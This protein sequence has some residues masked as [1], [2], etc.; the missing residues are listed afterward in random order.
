MNR[1]ILEVKNVY[2]E[3]IFEWAFEGMLSCGGDGG[4]AI[5]CKNYEEALG[6]FK[7]WH[8]KEYDKVYNGSEYPT[9]TKDGI[10]A[11]WGQEAIV[12]SSDIDLELW[13]GEDI[14]I[15]K[16]DCPF[17][18]SPKNTKFLRKVEVNNA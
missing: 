15:I 17:A 12:F 1:S 2:A 4:S 8:L 11:S 3:R 9:H 7:D 13:E 14:F 16:E 18:F 5:V 6:W 10:V